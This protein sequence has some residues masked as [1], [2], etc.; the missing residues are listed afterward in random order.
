VLLYYITD[1]RGFDGNESERR[2][3][4]LRRI[5]E[6]ANAGIDYIQLR[7]KDLEPADLEL[8]AR[9]ALRVVRE[10]SPTTKLLI[11][12]HAEIALE[13][14]AD[15][16][17][18]PAGSMRPSDL[19]MDWLLRNDRDPLIGVSAHSVK[20]VRQAENSG[21]S[22]IVL[23]PIFEKVDTDAQP[24]G[25]AVLREACAGSHIPVLALGGVNVGNA[26]ACLDAGATGIAGIRLYQHGDV[27]KTVQE[28]REMAPH[29]V[30][31]A[32]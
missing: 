8:L 28:L 5:G 24:I 16:V 31:T 32:N 29:K 2:A 11:N 10:S 19:R 17:H 15:G 22:F 25:L 13:V 9:E 27:S 21:A 23:A 3:A 4:L 12:T 20:E 6:A 30:H 1:R 7:E 14:G 18:L 26:R